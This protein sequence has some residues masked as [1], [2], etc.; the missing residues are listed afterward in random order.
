MFNFHERFLF[1]YHSVYDT[2]H[3]VHDT[4][5]IVND[6]VHIFHDTVHIVHLRRCTTFAQSSFKIFHLIFIFQRI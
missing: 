6:T 1:F 4:V 5:H 3:I 2:V